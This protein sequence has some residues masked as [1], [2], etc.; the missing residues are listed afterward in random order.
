MSTTV[1]QSGAELEVLED[2]TRAGASRYDQFTHLHFDRQARAWRGHGA[3]TVD[4][5]SRDD[6][7]DARDLRSA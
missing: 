6:E 5:T 2:Q 7:R 1:T 3:I 4:A